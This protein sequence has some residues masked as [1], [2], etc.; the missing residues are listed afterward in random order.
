MSRLRCVLCALAVFLWAVPLAPAHAHKP[1]D[2]YL[3]I[4]VDGD[5]IEGQWDIALRDL[6]FAIGL[7]TDG[8][9]GLTWDEVRGRHADIAAYAL[10]RLTLTS[11]GKPCASQAAQHLIDVHSDGAYEVLRFKARCAGKVARL[12]IAYSLFFD[13]DPQHRGLVNIISG[14][15]SATGILSPERAA[16]DFSVEGQGR[17]REFIAYLRDGV[18]HIWTGFDHILFLIS[19]LLPAVLKRQAGRWQP[20]AEFR[21]SFVEV[22]KIVTAFSV[23]HSITLTL[24]A[25]GVVSLPSRW[26][27]AA[28]ALSVIVAALN[29]LYPL[30]RGRRWIAAFSFG[31]IHGL[32]FATVLTDLRLPQSVLALALFGF[33]AGVEVGQLAIVAVFLPLAYLLRASWFYQRVAFVGGSALIVLLA[34]IWLV[35][36]AFD[37]SL[38]PA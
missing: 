3:T 20:A 37:M 31:L 18:W 17:L 16:Q 9:G 12:G 29:N 11:D 14:G 33:N 13:I 7:D 23:A 34:S 4:E 36:R 27:E 6:D 2:S 15:H 32:G 1:S 19:L 25:L 21:T 30:V 24:G 35:E 38:I 10:S 28:I 26:V 5:A 22:L 8:S